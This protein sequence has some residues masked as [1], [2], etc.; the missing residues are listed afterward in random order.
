MNKN[1]ITAEL[2]QEMVDTFSPEERDYFRHCVESV[3]RCFM[4]DS[5]EVG[6]LITGNIENGNTEI[7]QIGLDHRDATGLLSAV[8]ASRMADVAAM[9]TPKEKLN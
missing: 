7:F 6:L 4:A 8:L 2:F 9:N 5:S 3:A 1:P